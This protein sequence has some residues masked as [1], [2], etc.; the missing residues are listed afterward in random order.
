M[1]SFVKKTEATLKNGKVKKGF[2]EIKMLTKTGKT[3]IRYK[4]DVP[5]KPKA[6]KEKV[7]E[8]K[9][10]KKVTKQKENNDLENNDLEKLKL[11]N[12]LE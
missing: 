4:R 11:L 12:I 3:M 5:A 8:V 2:K 1:N 10:S 6:K 7:V 9:K